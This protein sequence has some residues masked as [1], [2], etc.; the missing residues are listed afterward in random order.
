MFW[1]LTSH[2]LFAEDTLIFNEA[3]LDHLR[4][5]W[6]LFL[7]LEAVSRLKVNLANSVS[8]SKWSNDQGTFPTL[9]LI[10]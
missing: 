9:L 8:L 6:C 1:G 3:D 4:H 7:C 2:L 10:F 5:L